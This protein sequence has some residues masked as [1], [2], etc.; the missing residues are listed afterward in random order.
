MSGTQSTLVRLGMVRSPRARLLCFPRAGSG[1]AS[2]RPLRSELPPDIDVCA[3]RL[4]GRESRRRDTPL[5]TMD[6][7]VAEVVKALDGL[8]DLP[9]VLVGYCSGANVAYQ[10][11]RELLRTGRGAPA[12]LLVLSKPGPRSIP[13][14]QW[15][16]TLPEP[17]LMAYLRE[18]GMTPESVLSDPELFTMFEPVI[19]ADFQV[20]E[21]HEDNDEGALDI[22]VTVVGA[23]DDTLVDFADL[24]AWRDHTSREFT[25][26]VIPGGH[27]FLNAA[28]GR[29]GRVVSGEL[30]SL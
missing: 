4:P 7:A 14:E 5:T 22:P 19:R 18:S 10:V 26:T 8:D 6:E 24:L 27:D 11:A 1:T 29:L 16:H 30:A 17:K 15:V 2:F 20:F 21:T 23:R 9:L 3:L 13:P 12:K 25:L 28:T